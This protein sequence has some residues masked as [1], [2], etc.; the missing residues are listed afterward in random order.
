M[1]YPDLTADMADLL[2]RVQ[3]CRWAICLGVYKDT[4]FLSVRTRNK[5]GAGQLVQAV[6]GDRGTAGGHG[7]I[8]FCACCR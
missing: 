1:Q 8:L 6:V 3:D 5:R 7:S 4:L 2:L